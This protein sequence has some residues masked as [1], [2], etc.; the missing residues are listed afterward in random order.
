LELRLQ[1]FGI[2]FDGDSEITV[3]RL[4]REIFEDIARRD[5]RFRAHAPEWAAWMR[6]VKDKALQKERPDRIYALM[7]DQMKQYMEDAQ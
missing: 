6:D 3:E 7:V 2:Q 1:G 5:T 4:E